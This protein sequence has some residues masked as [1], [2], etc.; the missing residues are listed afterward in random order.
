MVKVLEWVFFL[1]NR[2][3][4]HALPWVLLCWRWNKFPQQQ[5]GFSH[6]FPA[7]L[8]DIWLFL[9]TRNDTEKNLDS[10]T[11][12]CIGFWRTETKSLHNF[13][14]L[15]F[16]LKNKDNTLYLLDG[17]L[18]SMKSIIRH[19]YISI[20]CYLHTRTGRNKLV[21]SKQQLS[22]T[23][24]W[25]HTWKS[26]FSVSLCS[27]PQRSGMLHRT[28]WLSWTPTKWRCQLS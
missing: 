28:S 4:D 25:S 21:L 13:K 10:A 22:Q 19:I 17:K 24:H 9:R 1:S 15:L 6:P 23:W 8:K 26:C 18:G 3:L 12:L 27:F 16:P 20:T 2:K 14:S 7:L 5:E 11:N